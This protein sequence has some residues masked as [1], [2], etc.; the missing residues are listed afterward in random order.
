MANE[1]AKLAKLLAELNPQDLESL[2]SL[3]H[4]S[5]EEG[6]EYLE[7]LAMAKPQFNRLAQHLSTNSAQSTHVLNGKHHPKFKASFTIQIVRKLTVTTSPAAY[8]TDGSGNPV[9]LPAPLF[10]ISD[11]DSQYQN[12]I[13]SFLPNDGSVKLK[14]LGLTSD[15]NGIVLTYQN[16]ADTIE[17]TLTITLLGRSYIA[18]LNA[19]RTMF[20]T[21]LE[22]KVRIDNASA[23]NQFS[24]PYYLPYKS[25]LTVVSNDF[26][27]PN[28]YEPNILPNTQ[29]RDVP[30]EIKIDNERGL[31]PLIIQN[32]VP[33]VVGNS[34]ITQI[35]MFLKHYDKVGEFQPMSKH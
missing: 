28:D 34:W 19:T 10:L 1:T 21:L 33:A 16:A 8:L 9:N 5:D 23:Y 31:C 18:T 25:G 3:E 11:Y 12:T 20:M 17:E 24:Q 15:K 2:E 14:S 26:F 29:I 22:P 6:H 7:H 30:T 13:S 27:M 4:M 32:Y 35:T